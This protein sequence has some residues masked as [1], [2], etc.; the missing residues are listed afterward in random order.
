MKRNGISRTR[1]RADA[2]RRESRARFRQSP[3]LRTRTS[4]TAGTATIEIEDALIAD[5]I[6]ACQAALRARG[7]KA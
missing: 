2:G 1:R 6:A 5:M 3:I 7:S 4:E